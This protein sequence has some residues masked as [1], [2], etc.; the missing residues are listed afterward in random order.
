MLY[1]LIGGIMKR[2]YKILL[3]IIVGALI[4]IF[5]S[6]LSPKKEEYI[7]SLGDG[8]SL[9]I[10]SY[11]TI[12]KNFND[13][14]SEKL[15]YKSNQEFAINNLSPVLLKDYL[16]DN[17]LSSKTNKPIQQIIENSKLITLAIG[18]D[19]LMHLTINNKISQETICEFINEYEQILLLL[20]KI[21]PK[22]IY[23]I[24]MYPSKNLTKNDIIEINNKLKKLA[25]KYKVIYIDI[26]AISLNS[27]YFFKENDYHINYKAHKKIMELIIQNG[28]C[29]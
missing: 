15:N 7:V 4:T 26:L 9:G 1:F 12:T 2:R 6:N 18:M 17:N 22:P 14:L 27:D 21:T 16:L 29:L 11:N 24:G 5:L 19:E 28:L 13:Y 25:L 8:I 10:T 20:R 23:V 3:I